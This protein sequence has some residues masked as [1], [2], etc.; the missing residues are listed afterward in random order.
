MKESERGRERE[1]EWRYESEPFMVKLPDGQNGVSSL[2]QGDEGEREEEDGDGDGEDAAKSN[3]D[4]D[5]AVDA[6]DEGKW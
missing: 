2:I 5:E 4:E 1:G 3:G 6:G